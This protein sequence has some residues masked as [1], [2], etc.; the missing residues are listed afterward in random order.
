[1]KPI[2]CSSRSR[3]SAAFNDVSLVGSRFEGTS[4]LGGR[5]EE[6]IALVNDLV[7]CEG[8]V[9]IRIGRV[10]REV[11]LNNWFRASLVIIEKEVKRRDL[12][13]NQ[14]VP[15]IRDCMLL[16]AGVERPVL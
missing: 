15:D 6:F 13:I 8:P 3:L 1:M 16:A 12:G 9:L 14:L 7:K 5:H 11:P 2:F 4:I 10:N